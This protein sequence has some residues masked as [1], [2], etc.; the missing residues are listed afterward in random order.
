LPPAIA[1]IAERPNDVIKLRGF[2]VQHEAN[3][4]TAISRM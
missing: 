1:V 3:H 4:T 2:A